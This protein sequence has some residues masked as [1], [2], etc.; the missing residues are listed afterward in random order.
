MSLILAACGSA[1]KP[2][3]VNAVEESATAK[4]T[5]EV[6]DEGVADDLNAT[7]VELGGGEFAV[8]ASAYAPGEDPPAEES[9]D[10]SEP[11]EPSSNS[12]GLPLVIYDTD[13]G[14]DID[15]ALALAMLHSY[16]KLGKIELAAV[17]VSRNSVPGAQYSDAINT[18]FGRPDIP[19]GINRKSGA[20]FDD[21]QFYPKM[22]GTWPQ[23]VADQQI[24]DGF[25]LQ[26]RIMAEALAAGRPV[27]LIQT[28]FSG[29]VSQLLD[30]PPDSISPK[31]GVELAR[32]SVSLLSIMAGSIELGIVE[33]NIEHEVGPARNLFAKWPGPM[34]VSPFELGNAITYP[35]RAIRDQLNWVDRHPVKEAYEFQ[36]LQ[37]HVDAPPYYDMRSW[38][39]TSVIEAVEP[40]AGY[41]LTSA[42]G[43]MV[44]D[45]TGRTKFRPGSGQHYVLD[46]AKQY[47]G[48][49]RQRVVNRMIEL[50][51]MQP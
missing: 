39:L 30:S 36:D 37:W 3:L 38:D 28:G 23:D 15:D 35:Y 40:D 20:Y 2:E 4:A 18:F 27:L 45:G 29:N 1:P 48:E 19:I 21:R 26:R 32:D 6:G 50:V 43:T 33:F 22:A 17:T 9:Q 7:G 47:S 51:S 44:V 5:L 14:P 10:G 42:P 25:K 16:E 46:R 41:F 49:Q 8:G 24:E 11:M 13:M 34:A 12:G 31:N